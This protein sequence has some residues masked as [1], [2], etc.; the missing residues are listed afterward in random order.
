MKILIVHKYHYLRAGACTHLFALA[1]LLEKHGH[2]V[3]HF[4]MHHPRNF[5][6]KHENFFVPYTDYAEELKKRGPMPKIKALKSMF[7]STIAR[8]KFSEALD[9]FK[10]DVIHLHNI[11]KHL[12]ISILYEAKKRNIPIVWTMHDYSL[13][14]PNY[15]MLAG[16]KVCESCRHHNYLAPVIKRCVKDSLLASAAAAM[17]KFLNDMQRIDKKV[18]AYISPSQ[19]LK[20]K[21]AEFGFDKGKIY[22]MPNFFN[23]SK[24]SIKQSFREKY[25]LYLGRISGE[26]GIITLCEATKKAGVRLKILGEGPIKNELEQHYVSDKIQFLGYKT[27]KPLAHIREDAWFVVVPSEWYENNPFSIIE[28]FADGVPVI[29]ARIG[30]IPEL[31]QEGKSGFMFTPKSVDELTDKLKI[32]SKM[33]IAQRSQ[34]GKNAKQF[35]KREYDPEKYYVNL[36]QIYK[37][38]LKNKL[39]KKQK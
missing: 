31:I 38:V 17:E 5:K 18:D 37:K 23:V 7:Y 2:E 25:F 32:A 4:S 33:S 9:F 13:I 24:K 30:G 39:L 11:H 15:T 6:Y 34:F 8:K 12:T 3:M 36:M 16:G 14:C 22:Y 20:D 35:I 28:S 19:F 21:F 26:K 29:G 10:P 27:G 1:N